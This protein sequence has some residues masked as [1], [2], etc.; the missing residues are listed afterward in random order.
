MYNPQTTSALPQPPSPLFLCRGRLS[1]LALQNKCARLFL[2]VSG[3]GGRSIKFDF[4][5]SMSWCTFNAAQLMTARVR[6]SFIVGEDKH[7]LINHHQRCN[8]RATCN[9]ADVPRSSPFDSS[10][11]PLSRVTTRLERQPL[12]SHASPPCSLERRP[13]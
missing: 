1:L 13:T 8:R 5:D 4:N 3:E 7:P 2:D 10:G 9:C 11:H 6:Y 12:T